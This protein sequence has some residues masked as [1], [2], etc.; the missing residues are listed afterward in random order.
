MLPGLSRS[1]GSVDKFKFG[2]YGSAVQPY[3]SLAAGGVHLTFFD[4]VRVHAGGGILKA[5][6]SIDFIVDPFEDDGESNHKSFSYG[7]GVTLKVPGWKWSPTL[8]LERSFH[9]TDSG[10][11]LRKYLSPS[12]GVE[13]RHNPEY[14]FG[15]KIFNPMRR[16]GKKWRFKRG[17]DTTTENGVTTKKNENIIP[18]G[19]GYVGINF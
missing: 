14:F 2:L 1:E 5:L 16:N 11:I 13:Y 15:I 3:L 17:G 4:T 19:S 10:T 18:L 6:W 12:I 9:Y 8:G 7:Y